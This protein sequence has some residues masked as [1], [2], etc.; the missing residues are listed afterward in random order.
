M[1]FNKRG[2]LICIPSIHFILRVYIWLLLTIKILDKIQ[3]AQIAVFSEL[4]V[5]NAVHSAFIQMKQFF[6]VVSQYISS[7]YRKDFQ[8]FFEKNVE[9]KFEFLINH[10]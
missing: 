5:L 10:I 6:L 3:I 7:L 2:A 8:A 1:N 4:F 9:A